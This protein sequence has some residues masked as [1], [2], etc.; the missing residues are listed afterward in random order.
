MT[1]AIVKVNTSVPVTTSKD[2]AAFDELVEIV[3][4]SVAEGSARVYADTLHKWAAWCERNNV[5]PLNMHIQN[6]RKFLV[7][8]MVGFSTRKREQYILTKAM[9]FAAI[10]DD[11]FD[12]TYRMLKLLK[13]PKE[14]MPDRERRGKSL[15]P[16]EA[17]KALAA[18]KIEKKR[19]GHIATRALAINALIA[20]TGMRC[21]EAAALRIS[22]V[23]FE[24]FVV[25]IW[26]GKRDKKRDVSI[27]G[28]FAI[29][30][31]D[32]WLSV[33]GR[34]RIYL[35]PVAYKNKIGPDSKPSIKSVYRS[36]KRI[37]KLTGIRMYT[38]RWRHTWATL[39]AQS[40][41]SLLIIKD[42]LG[43][44]SLETTSIYAEAVDAKTRR[45]Q[46]HLGFGESLNDNDY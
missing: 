14:N 39:S 19:R 12:R 26:H 25:K 30:L 36:V 11:S 16:V 8:D 4:S 28:E 37:E 13:T 18:W 3:K 17:D 20:A 42:Q 23:D 27:A 35:F 46:I 44:E 34:D 40:G 38:H 6:V 22:D 21:A 9:Q 43:H 15:N 10:R 1:N 7:Q 24:N 2:W 32:D 41:T 31:L 29:P 33:I 5:H 45:S